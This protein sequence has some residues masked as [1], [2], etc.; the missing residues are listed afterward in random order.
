M[1]DGYFDSSDRV[2]EGRGAIAAYAVRPD[3]IPGMRHNATNIVINGD[4]DHATG[5]AFLIGYS[6]SDGYKVICTG[7]YADELTRTAEGW[8]FS[9]RIFT[10][11]R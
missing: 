6:V 11:D 8:R 2:S 7:R 1:P 4:G 9:R 3:K 5:S 10:I